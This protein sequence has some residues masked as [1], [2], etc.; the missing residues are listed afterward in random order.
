ME[1]EKT[2]EELAEQLNREANENI[3]A[4]KEEMEKGLIT[5]EQFEGY[6]TKITQKLQNELEKL[7][8]MNYSN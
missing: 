3:E 1:R 7:G 6:Q 2:T 8:L 4:S 5:L